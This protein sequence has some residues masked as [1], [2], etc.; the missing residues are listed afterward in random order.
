MYGGGSALLMLNLFFLGKAIFQG[1]FVPV[2]PILAGILTAAGLLLIVYA[3]HRARLEDKRDHRR[4]SR[5]AHQLESPLRALQDD[6]QQLIKSADKLPAEA[7]LKL[8]HMETKSHVLLENVRDVFL[9]LQAQEGKV[10]GDTRTYD[11]CALVKEAIDRA[12]PLASARNVEIITKQHCTD[13]P[14]K[15]DRRLFLIALIHLIEN[16]VLY[17]LKPGLVNVAV[18]RGQR[19]AR[20]IVQDR[21]VGIPP[22]DEGVVFQPFA[23][24]ESAQQFDG[25]GIGV[26][27]TLARLILREFGGDLIYRSRQSATGSEFEIKLP[28]VRT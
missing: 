19:Y 10:S 22:N 1:N 2:V 15:V 27:L 13:A 20:V 21:G 26:G 25:D 4:I 24:G 3:E 6:L 7:R 11:L 28:L 18:T 16:G 23:R 17:T 8:K 12:T 5:V 9:T 14:V